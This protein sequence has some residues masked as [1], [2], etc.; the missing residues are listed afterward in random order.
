MADKKQAVWADCA[1]YGKC[2]LQSRVEELEAALE[3]IMARE[4]GCRRHGLGEYTSWRIAEQAL[5]GGK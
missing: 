5:K 2:K 4:R 1:Y 3:K